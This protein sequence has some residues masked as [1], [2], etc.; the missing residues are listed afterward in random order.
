[1]PNHCYTR[2]VIQA[3]HADEAKEILDLMT[4]EPDGKTVVMAYWNEPGCAGGAT[5]S[6]G[7]R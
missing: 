6:R 3:R 2:W 4:R 7:G 1:M 5:S